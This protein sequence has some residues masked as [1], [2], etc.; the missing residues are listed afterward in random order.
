MNVLHQSVCKA[1]C[2]QEKYIY[3]INKIHLTSNNV[4][5]TLFLRSSSVVL[6]TYLTDV[7]YERFDIWRIK[8]LRTVDF[9]VI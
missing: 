3:R 2:V 6:F 4:S 1:Q 9:L 8:N 7:K 5:P